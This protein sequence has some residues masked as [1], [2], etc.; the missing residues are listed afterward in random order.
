MSSGDLIPSNIYLTWVL[1]V[2]VVSP[3][4]WSENCFPPR[5]TS[6]SPLPYGPG[7]LPVSESNLACPCNLTSSCLTGSE[8]ENLDL[9]ALKNSSAS[10]NWFATSG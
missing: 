5:F 10:M 8:F 9:A 1:R 2:P 4:I 3:I 7:I 6:G